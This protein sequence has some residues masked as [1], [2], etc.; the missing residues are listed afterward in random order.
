[1]KMIPA[2]SNASWTRSTVSTV[3]PTIRLLTRDAYS[4][5]TDPSP[6]GEFRLGPAKQPAGRPYLLAM[7]Q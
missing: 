1:M 5:L 6:I 3:P 7:Q 4:H 2:F